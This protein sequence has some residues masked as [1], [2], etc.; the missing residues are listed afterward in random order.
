MFLRVLLLIFAAILFANSAYS[1]EE[2]P[3]PDGIT[4][5]IPVTVAELD[6]NP[7][8]FHGK[9]IKVRGFLAKESIYLY[10]FLDLNNY[11]AYYIHD[12]EMDFVYPV[13]IAFW[14]EIYAKNREK[15]ITDDRPFFPTAFYNLTLVEIIG[16]FDLTETGYDQETGKQEVVVVGAGPMISEVESVK[17][18]DRPSIPSLTIKKLR[19]FHE[20][21]SGDA[22]FYEVVFEDDPE[23]DAMNDLINVFIRAVQTRNLEVLRQSVYQNGTEP[24]HREN[25]GDPAYGYTHL[26]FA[27]GSLLQK[28]LAGPVI[29]GPEFLRPADY[30]TNPH[31]KDWREACFCFDGQ[32]KGLWPI[33]L[34][35]RVNTSMQDDFVCI[36]LTQTGE[37]WKWHF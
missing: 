12:D 24:P 15:F 1:F 25:L 21:K 23:Y 27:E 3:E 36:G 31:S 35:Q 11:I 18:L 26:L 2:N 17:I 4:E 28:A 22:A 5:P 19:S 33:T 34:S 6:R 29:E 30:E 16:T 13:G 32:C 37:G 7:E 14:P 9:R 8:Y 10:L 20:A